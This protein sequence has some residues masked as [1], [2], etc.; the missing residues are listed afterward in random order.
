MK[1]TVLGKILLC[2]VLFIGFDSFAQMSITREN[3]MP[4]IGDSPT[5]YGVDGICCEGRGADVIWDFSQLH[6]S[7]EKRVIRFSSDPIGTRSI[8]PGVRRFFVE[9][10]DSFLVKGFQTSLDS[11]TYSDPLIAMTY[12]LSYGDSISYSFV[13][14][15]K[16]CET[17]GLSQTGTQIIKADARGSMRLPDN[18]RLSDVLQVHY[19]VSKKHQFEEVNPSLVDT[20]IVKL[21]LEEVYCWYASGSRYPVIVYSI[22]TCY[23][24]EEQVSSLTKAYCC[25]PDSIMNKLISLDEDRYAYQG[26]GNENNASAEKASTED[27]PFA[28]QL[29]QSGNIVKLSLCSPKEITINLVL[30]S[31]LGILYQN[32]TIVCQQDEHYEL[33]FDCSAYPPGGYIIYLNTNGNVISEKFH[34]Y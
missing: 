17:Y 30:A 10:G 29:T 8:E 1:T 34:T 9:N 14:K 24:N 16:Y 11:V 19:L 32:R 23:A 13:G 21:D 4:Q 2:Y 7:N 25:F 33:Q 15:G 6:I 22:N 5:Y 3:N 28:Y 26:A 20:S 27:V 31:T 18:M 12:P